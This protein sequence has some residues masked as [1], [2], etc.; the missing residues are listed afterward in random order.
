[1]K[2]W[3]LLLVWIFVV[4]VLWKMLVSKKKEVIQQVPIEQAARVL[5][6]TKAIL[7]DV[8]T[9]EERLQRY[10]EGSLHLP[11]DRLVFDLEEKIPDKY[12]PIMFC[13]KQGIRSEGAAVIARQLGYQSIYY[14]GSCT[15]IK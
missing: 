6:D 11:I 14:T 9:L 3:I 2:K 8:R 10:R 4:L 13:C 12:Q 7:I 5:E 1:M 15:Q